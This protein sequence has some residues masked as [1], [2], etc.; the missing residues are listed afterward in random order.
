MTTQHLTAASRLSIHAPT[1]GATTLPVL[2][3][4]PLCTFNPRSYKRSD[5]MKQTRRVKSS[6]FNPRSYKRSD[7][8]NSLFSSILIYTFNPRSYKRSDVLVW[9]KFTSFLSLSIH[10]PTRGATLFF[11]LISLYNHSFNPR[12][13]KRSDSSVILSSYG[14]QTFN[15]RSYKRSDEELDEIWETSVIFQS[16]LLQEERQD[17]G[18]CC[19]HHGT[20]SIHAPTRGATR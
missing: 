5:Q 4:I 13:Y 6:S 18:C 16:T 8:S 3:S 19:K 11:L 7:C 10:A 1:R 9:F 12:S 2:F 15:P 20:L 17:R 14:G